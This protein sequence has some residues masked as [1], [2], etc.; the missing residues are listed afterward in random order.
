MEKVILVKSNGACF[1]YNASR[2]LIGQVLTLEG[3]SRPYYVKSKIDGLGDTE[4]DVNMYNILPAP[5]ELPSPPHVIELGH[6]FAADAEK[7]MFSCYEENQ[8]DMVLVCPVCKSNG[9]F[10]YVTLR[11]EDLREGVAECYRCHHLAYID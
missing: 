7:F 11:P 8:R 9:T 3:H 4:A 1:D 2:L 6:I 5:I 10:P